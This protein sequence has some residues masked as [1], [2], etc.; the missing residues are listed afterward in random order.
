MAR[1]NP[2]ASFFGPSTSSVH[3]KGA[4]PD[5]PPKQGVERPISPPIALPVRR[6]TSPTP[7]SPKPSFLSVDQSD[8]HSTHS[9]SQ[10]QA[11][12]FQVTAYTISR[13]IRYAEAHKNIT[14]AVRT[15][16]REE[17]ARLPD[18][19]VDRIMK[20]VVSGVCPVLGGAVGQELLKSHSGL[21]EGE[22][23]A[24]DFADPTVAGEK[25]QE[26]VEGVYDELMTYY[27]SEEYV[28]SS[29]KKKGSGNVPW[30]R[31]T[32]QANTLK[33]NMEKEAISKDDFVEKEASEGTER[34]EA[35]MS[36]LLYN[37]Y[38]LLAHQ[39][40]T[41]LLT[42]ACS[43]LSSQTTQGMTRCCRLG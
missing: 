28:N 29:L 11:E 2:F 27:R 41:Q 37:R 22:A 14:K 23:L 18:K 42:L 43:H 35:V 33:D 16:V 21:S 9:Q 40:W 12:G 36:R 3:D 8:T 5:S 25:F 1:I 13:P 17:L 10:E 20:L 4:D 15:V 38:V 32:S 34:V 24:F 30:S 26:V 19:V 6:A 31:S 7:S 39:Y